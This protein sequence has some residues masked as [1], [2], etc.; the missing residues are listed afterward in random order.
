[1]QHGVELIPSGHRHTTACQGSAG[2]RVR[3][4]ANSG[5]AVLR[6]RFVKSRAATARSECLRPHRLDPGRDE[7]W[8]ALRQQHHHPQSSTPNATS[9]FRQDDCCV[10]SRR[11]DVRQ[12][13]PPERRPR[14]YPSPRAASRRAKDGVLQEANEAS[15]KQLQPLPGH[16][17]PRCP[18]QPQGGQENRR[19]AP[20]RDGAALR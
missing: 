9:Q 8:R 3:L 10:E 5:E 14:F 2:L 6:Q 15:P 20:W 12:L 18:P 16:R 4:A 17:G 7:F 19:R 13:T 1:M 11:L